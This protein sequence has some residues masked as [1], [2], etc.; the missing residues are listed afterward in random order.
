MKL[1][2]KMK[3]LINKSFFYDI[4]EI[5]IYKELL[6]KKVSDKQISKELADFVIDKLE[7]YIYSSSRGKKKYNFFN[8]LIIILNGAITYMSSLNEENKEITFLSVLVTVIYSIISFM[9]Y[10]TRWLNYRTVA[11]ELEKVIRDFFV[12]S[13]KNS[14]VDIEKF[15]EKIDYIISLDTNNF[16]VYI[17]NKE[18]TFKE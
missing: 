12:D 16:K 5:E 18:E 8:I 4:E 10:K 17:E 1:K 11:E 2:E 14:E 9:D 6:N 13:K 7:Y 15:I 3:F